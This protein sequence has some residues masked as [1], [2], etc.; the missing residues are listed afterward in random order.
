MLRSVVVALALSLAAPAFAQ[1]GHRHGQAGTSPY[2]GEQARAI[3]SLSE[4]DLAELRRGGG[5]G[6][7]K[8][9]E[10]NGYPGPAHLLELKDAIPLEPDQVAAIEAV[11]EAMQAQAIAEG[12]RLIAREAELDRAFRE[13]T[14]TAAGLRE[15]LGEIEASR[16]ALR[17]VHLSAHLATVPLLSEAQVARYVI[18]RG[19]GNDPCASVPDGHDPAMWRRHNG[20]G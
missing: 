8:P 12:E 4:D 3:K 18:L 15:L 20:C 10:L 1:E 9:A 7:A 19:Y 16:A 6:L 14:V 11:F 5:W 17:Y 13:H 2:A